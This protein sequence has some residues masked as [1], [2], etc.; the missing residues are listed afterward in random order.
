MI[1][2]VEIARRIA[3]QAHREQFDKAGLPYIEHPRRVA[4][5]VA[6]VDGRPEAVAAAWLH[7]VV[8]DCGVGLDD[9][10]AHGLDEAVLAAVEALTRRP[11]EGD[12]YYARVAGDELARVV[13][14]ADIWDNTNPERLA[15]LDPETRE[16]L[17]AKY[18]HASELIS[19]R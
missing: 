4:G 16:R 18:A 1:D 7:D 6:Q 15:K 11:D 14:A 17:L 12:G 13:K 10:R 2:Q 3:E 5:R 19:A 9:L 8:E